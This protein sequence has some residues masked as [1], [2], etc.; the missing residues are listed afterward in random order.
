MNVQALFE[1]FRKTTDDTSAAILTLA[2]VMQGD[3]AEKPLTVKQAAERLN[4]SP[5]C[6]YQ[7]IEAGKLK[8]RRVGNGRGTIRI[9]PADLSPTIPLADLI[10]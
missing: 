8:H 9:N 6:I 4:V 2:S 7:M 3:Q 10:R 5:D 1:Q